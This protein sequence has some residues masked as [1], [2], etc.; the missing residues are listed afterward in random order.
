MRRIRIIR[1][2]KKIKLQLLLISIF[3]L[4]S[5]IFFYFSPDFFVIRKIVCTTQFGECVDSLR[6]ILS[7]LLGKQTLFVNR[8]DVENLLLDR[9]EVREVSIKKKLR[10]LVVK[11]NVSKPVAAIQ[12]G[13]NY[14][15]VDETGKVVA[16]TEK[17]FLPPILVQAET[18]DTDIK[19][20]ILTVA[21]IKELGFNPQSELNNGELLVTVNATQVLIPKNKSPRLAAGSLQSI[22]TGFTMKGKQPV[23]IDLRFKNPIVSF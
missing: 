14:L 10:E 23:K 15:L 22:I 13:G 18:K 2:L 7:P 6:S 17:T 20:A 16:R 12:S 1:F 21:F 3:L 9:P 5:F 4:L 19:W 11:L 8:R